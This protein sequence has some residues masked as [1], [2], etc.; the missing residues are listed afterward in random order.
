MV[1]IMIILLKMHQFHGNCPDFG[2]CFLE[3]TEEFDF[4]KENSAMYIT[5][6]AIFIFLMFFFHNGLQ[7][8]D[9]FCPDLFFSNF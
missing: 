8:F 5:L 9:I 2:S 6:L 4:L 7:F 3:M 1:L